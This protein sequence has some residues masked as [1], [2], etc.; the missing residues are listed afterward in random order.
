M[1]VIER[2]INVLAGVY[3]RKKCSPVMGE[4]SD[5]GLG[6][7][8]KKATK[9]NSRIS[10]LKA[11]AKEQD[12]KLDTTFGFLRVRTANQVMEEAAKMPDPKLLWDEFWVE[13]EVCCLFAEGNLGKSIYAVQISSEIAKQEKVLYFDFE[14]S[15]K[16]FQ[17]RYTDEETQQLH[18]FPDNFLRVDMSPDSM[19]IFTEDSLLQYI[20]NVA[21]KTDA[22]VLVIDNLTWL[23][24]NADKGAD[25]GTFMMKLSRL[26][27]KYNWSI[28]VISHT[29]KR[30]PTS[31]ITKN[32]MAGS[33]KIYAFLDSAF[34]IGKSTQDPSLRYIKQIKVRQANFKY[35]DDN[36][37]VCKIEKDKALTQLKHIG[38]SKER[39]HLRERTDE[40]DAR[41]EQEILDL[42]AKGKSIR[43]IESETI[44]NRSRIA[45]VLKKHEQG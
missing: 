36:V 7:M 13:G 33:F 20:E 10:A 42:H 25:A 26:K 11:D 19:V 21:V 1:E 45:R 44:Y 4:I 3:V 40:D 16:Q 35:D 43:Q 5:A 17:R 2:N 9:G 38:F 34:A 32:D 27:K 37:I 12:K 28:L 8:V 14:L 29:P 24:N 23:C 22:K 18:K 41:M 39:E 31:P 6:A 15:D 30:P